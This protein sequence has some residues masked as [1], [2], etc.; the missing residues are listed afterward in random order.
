MIP[1]KLKQTDQSLAPVGR[2]TQGD[3]PALSL[4]LRDRLSLLEASELSAIEE[5]LAYVIPLFAQAG[6]PQSVFKAFLTTKA[7]VLLS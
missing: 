6:V 7:S 3:A 1:E 2:L 4:T 5:Q